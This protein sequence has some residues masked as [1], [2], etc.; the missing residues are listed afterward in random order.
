MFCC[1]VLSLAAQNSIEFLG[2]PIRGNTKT[3]FA[4]TLKEKGYKYDWGKDG[5]VWYRGQF[6]GYDA[7]VILIP[8]GEDDGI[9][10]VQVSLKDLNPIKFGQLFSDLVRKYMAKYPNFKYSN[11]IT[12]EGTSVMFSKFMEDGLMDCI[13]LKSSVEG[14]SLEFRISYYVCLN[15]KDEDKASDNSKGIDLDDL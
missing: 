4:K 1:I 7:D 15:E 12:T 3:A 6:A 13:I 10:G 14:T 5:F 11:D 9:R 2:M 8:M